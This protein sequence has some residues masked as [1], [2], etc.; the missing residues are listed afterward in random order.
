M[1]QN[2]RNTPKNIPTL[3]AITYFLRIFTYL[4]HYRAFLVHFEVIVMYLVSL[5]YFKQSMRLNL[6]PLSVQKSYLRAFHELF[7]SLSRF[8]VS[9]RAT[10]ICTV[11]PRFL[12]MAN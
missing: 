7:T 6:C 4:C 12:K 10:D 9:S 1:K 2:F 11:I 8:L 5:R 3:S